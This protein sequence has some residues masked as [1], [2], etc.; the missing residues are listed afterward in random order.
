VVGVGATTTCGRDGWFRDGCEW[1]RDK[2]NATATQR[3]ATAGFGA[4]EEAPAQPRA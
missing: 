4:W 3:N 1:S 2:A